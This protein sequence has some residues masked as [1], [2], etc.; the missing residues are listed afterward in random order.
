MGF[1]VELFV[2]L[3]VWLLLLP[4]TPRKVMLTQGQPRD[5]GDCV[6][7]SERVFWM[8]RWA[9]RR[10]RRVLAGSHQWWFRRGG[11]VV[12]YGSWLS[13]SER[14][15]DI[16]AMAYESRVVIQELEV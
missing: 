11:A 13:R 9:S 15:R 16:S 7:S 2:E 4:R 14:R 12:G 3:A 6:A 1:V 8:P 10:E 5:G